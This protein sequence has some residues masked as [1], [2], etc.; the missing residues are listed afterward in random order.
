MARIGAVIRRRARPATDYCDHQ[1]TNP[2][3]R[4][5]VGGIADLV[6]L[7]CCRSCAPRRRC[8]CT[9]AGGQQESAET[10]TGGLE[11]S[12]PLFTP[13]GGVEHGAATSSVPTMTG[14]TMPGSPS[15][16]TS[17]GGCAR[18]SRST[19]TCGTPDGP[20]SQPTGCSPKKIREDDYQTVEHYWA[21][22][23]R[24]AQHSNRCRE[25][26]RNLGPARGKEP[27]AG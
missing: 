14:R 1:R 21:V 5:P 24:M 6:V 22:L 4:P 3:G 16:S 2:Q 20:G 18:I 27:P 8:T 12:R 13:L 15:S 10:P 17:P 11:R 9:S 26:H 23:Q 19:T 25:G 7:R